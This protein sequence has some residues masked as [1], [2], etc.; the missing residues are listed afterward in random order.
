[1]GKIS[2]EIDFATDNRI[3]VAISDTGTGVPIDKQEIIFDAFRQADDTITR[4]FG[5]NGLGL[6]ICKSIVEKMG[7]SIHVESDGKNGSLFYFYIPYIPVKYQREVRKG[8]I[9]LTLFPENLRKR[10]RGFVK[11]QKVLVVEDNILNQKVIIKML[12]KLSCN[13]EVANNGIEAVEMAK[14][15]QFP[16]IFMDLEMPI[17]DGKTA[18]KALRLMPQ[19]RNIPIIA[20]T[21][22]VLGSTEKD[23]MAQEF[24]FSSFLMKPATLSDLRE[25][26]DTM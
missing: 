17:M 2:F 9:D 26:L 21:A 11:D 20:F 18:T 12:Q 25:V 6:A 5:G 8:S 10:R 3:K 15:E 16:L 19:Y 13:I 24:G 23:K 4:K 1:M 22:H 14:K 7:G